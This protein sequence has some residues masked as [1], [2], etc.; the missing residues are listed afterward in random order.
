M[1]FGPQGHPTPLPLAHGLEQATS[2]GAFRVVREGGR[3]EL[4]IRAFGG[5]TPL[6]HFTLDALVPKRFVPAWP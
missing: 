5:G 4:Q 3:H 2:H 6:Y 1:R